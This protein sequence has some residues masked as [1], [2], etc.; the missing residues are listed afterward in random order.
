MPRTRGG[1]GGGG[2][3]TGDFEF[4]GGGGSFSFTPPQALNALMSRYGQLFGNYADYLSGELPQV[5]R[6]NARA[7][8]LYEAGRESD[9][10]TASQSRAQA[11]RAEQQAEEA[12]LLARKDEAARAQAEEMEKR[13]SQYQANMRRANDM[14]SRPVY[15]P[16]SR[17][18]EYL[19]GANY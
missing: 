18:P 9:L 7:F 4:P 19:P 2:G 16:Y 3:A 5:S 15:Q 14:Y 6:R 11:L 13:K 8:D 10:E 12:R 1:G 17:L